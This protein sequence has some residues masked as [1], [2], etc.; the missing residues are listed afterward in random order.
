M[1][2]LVLIVLTYIGFAFGVLAGMLNFRS[3]IIQAMVI[4][5][6]ASIAVGLNFF[7]FMRETGLELFIK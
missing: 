4:F 1:N 7:V 6:S 2:V 5:I 3:P